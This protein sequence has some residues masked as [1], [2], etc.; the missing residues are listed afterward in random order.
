MK[1]RIFS[2][3]IAVA[4]ML[5][6]VSAMPVTADI[7]KEDAHPDIQQWSDFILDT[8]PLSPMWS[9]FEDYNRYHTGFFGVSDS[10][11]DML[12]E[13]VKENNFTLDLI[14]KEN[15][16][17]WVGNIDDVWIDIRHNDAGSL[18]VSILIC[19]GCDN[20]P[21]EC[22]WCYDCDNDPCE[23]P[24]PCDDC[25]K[26][27]CECPMHP[28]LQEWTDKI[29]KYIA[30]TFKSAPQNI[31][32]HAKEW[33][34]GFSDFDEND[35]ETFEEWLL[36]QGFDDYGFGNSLNVYF[37]YD[38]WDEILYIH[39]YLDECWD[40]VKIPCICKRPCDD[41]DESKFTWIRVTRWGMCW[42][43]YGCP[44]CESLN[45]SLWETDICSIRSSRVAGTCKI[46]YQCANVG[47]CGTDEI[48]DDCDWSTVTWST[49]N[50]Y[51]GTCNLCSKTTT[52]PCRSVPGGSYCA[53]AD[54]EWEGYGL[55]EI[56]GTCKKCGEWHWRGHD[57]NIAGSTI[58]GCVRR[59]VTCT[60]AGCNIA[61]RSWLLCDSNRTVSWTR[62]T[63]FGVCSD[64]GECT[65]CKRDW[66]QSC[67][68]K[69]T[70]QWNQHTQ[71]DACTVCNHIYYRWGAPAAIPTVTSVT[72]SP[73]T[74]TVQI[75]TTRQFTASVT[76]TNNPATTVT[77]S[78]TGN[79]HA[80]TTISSAG[81]LTVHA[82]EATSSSLTVRATST[83]NTG[84]SGTATVTISETPVGGGNTGNNRPSGGGG[85]GGGGGGAAD[86]TTPTTTTPTVIAATQAVTRAVNAL[87]LSASIPVTPMRFAAA[88]IQNVSIGADFAGQNAVLTRLNAETGELEFVSATT[89][90]A[91]GSA[92][93]NVPATGDYVILTFKTGDVT[94]TGEVQ[95]ADALAVLR[96]VAGVNELNSIQLFVANGKQGD[97]GTGEALSILRN[98]AGLE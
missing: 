41:C 90:S 29:I 63:S 50:I 43:V 91:G 19:I 16:N 79:S 3:F 72:V 24:E 94:G 48:Y 28:H 11:V 7:E 4:M 12:V 59:N 96:H 27:P 71:T 26:Y 37:W 22:F 35:V 25:G 31:S 49:T 89:V 20:T 18:F 13:K 61:P 39:V 85:G 8:I 1:K 23:C 95:T 5:S 32:K 81:L 57:W 77:W 62:G 6:L 86:T 15:H 98:V 14:V 38:D 67:Q 97:V 45:T 33:S 54:I 34:A 87:N 92:S 58:D 64:K 70:V 65:A 74:A 47:G 83:V 75:G 9:V 93:V 80:G 84:I 36:E 60:R 68:Y 76:G 51:S 10:V 21:C 30:D 69:G 56:E 53:A 55:C 88:G 42:L 2:V 46:R 52:R 17:I 40:C 82:E 44:D 66:F 73:A 78:L